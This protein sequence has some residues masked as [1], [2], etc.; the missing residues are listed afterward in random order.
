MVVV[1]LTG[2]DVFIVVEFIFDEVIIEVL[3][4]VEVLIVVILQ[5]TNQGQL[6]TCK[7]GSK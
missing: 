5:S 1:G 7:S 4:G 2:V 6:Q 3:V